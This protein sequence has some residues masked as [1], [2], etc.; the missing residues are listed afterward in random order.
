MKRILAGFFLAALQA[1]AFG[2]PAMATGK[3]YVQALVSADQVAPKYAGLMLLRSNIPAEFA[4]QQGGPDNTDPSRIYPAGANPAYYMTDAGSQ[5]TSGISQGQ[6]TLAIVQCV[7][8]EHNWS[9]TAYAGAVSSTVSRQGLVNGLIVMPDVQMSAVP[10]PSLGSADGNHISISISAYSDYGGQAQDLSIWRTAYGSQN[11]QWLGSVPNPTSLSS[12]VWNDVSVVANSLYNYSVTVDYAWPGGGGAGQLS[13]TPGV[14]SSDARG[15]SGPFAANLRQ[16]TPHGGAAATATPLPMQNGWLLYPN[17]VHGD[18][19]S[20][21]FNPNTLGSYTIQCYTLAGQLA[22][23]R[24]GA[25]QALNQM[26]VGVDIPRMASGI[27]LVRL[28]VTGS[29][30][31]VTNMPL[32]KLAVLK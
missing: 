23:T 18:S 31:S 6:G 29:N 30:G 21:A 1:Q 16:P 11:W 5:W 27:Y 9:G 7:P 12:A 13:G 2:N 32:K 17:P 28:E 14:Y 19:F 25:I 10:C 22:E 24:R 4:T 26:V 15:I 8:G 3:V 20:V